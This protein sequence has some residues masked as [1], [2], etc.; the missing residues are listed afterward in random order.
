[1]SIQRDAALFLVRCDS[2]IAA[3]NSEI[4]V[5]VYRDSPTYH[6]TPSSELSQRY[7]PIG[8]HMQA[9]TTAIDMR[10]AANAHLDPSLHTRTLLPLVVAAA[11]FVLDVLT[12]NGVVDGF[13]YVPA[14]LL[15]WW[16]PNANAAPFMAAALMPAMLFGFTLSPMGAPVWMAVTNRMVAT[17]I[18][19]LAAL[20]LW[21]NAKSMKRKDSVLSESQD[22]LRTVECS[23]QDDRLNISTWLRRELDVELRVVE[24][25]LNRLQRCEPDTLDLRTETLILRQAVQRARESVL[26]KATRL[27]EGQHQS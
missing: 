15:C 19:W 21:L 11:M 9:G 22:R 20:V 18:V 4:R 10:S 8:V 5:N 3:F 25:R 16:I 26:T 7:Y 2:C 17:S 6:P 13:L 12:P 27:D 23:A 14:I 1:M 24:W